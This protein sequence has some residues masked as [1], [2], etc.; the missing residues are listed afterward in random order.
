M[1]RLATDNESMELMTG[2]GIL[3]VLPRPPKARTKPTP[4]EI[5]LVRLVAAQHLLRAAKH[6]SDEEH[7]LAMRHTIAA[8]DMLVSAMEAEL[9]L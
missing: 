4:D 7:E 6:T 3:A 1:G 5:K 2:R 8:G 9:G